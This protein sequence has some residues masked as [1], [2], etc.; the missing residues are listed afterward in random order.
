MTAIIKAAKDL[1]L[2]SGDQ[3][4]VDLEQPNSLRKCPRQ[5]HEDG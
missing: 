4:V 5:N 3:T 1:V 2:D